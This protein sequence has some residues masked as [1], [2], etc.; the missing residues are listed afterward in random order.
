VGSAP[1]SHHRGWWA[2]DPHPGGVSLVTPG[3][4]R[5]L[6]T[7][8]CTVAVQLLLLGPP[9]SG[10]GTQGP[11]LARH[12]RVPHLSSGELLRRQ[13]KAGT[14]LGREVAGTLDR[15]ELVP[16]DVIC[17]LMEQA[18]GA[19]GVADGYV[20]D[21]FPR[22][23]AQARA[24]EGLLGRTGG[25]DAALY[26]DLPDEVVRQRLAGR[27]AQAQRS[28]DDEDVIERRLRIYHAE[29]RPLLDYYRGRG[30]LVSVDASPPPDDVTAAVVAALNARGTRVQGAGS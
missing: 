18:L 7:M 8:P 27:A 28:D 9:G 30:L 14:D 20:L 24:A 2:A 13:V 19:P 1:N 16:D 3:A 10:K 6:G 22:T 21:G 26:L 5:T 23:A 15:G 17:A 12:Y 11:R 25:L 29:I 4:P